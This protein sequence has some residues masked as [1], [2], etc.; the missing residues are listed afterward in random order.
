MIDLNTERM[1]GR[2]DVTIDGMKVNRLFGLNDLCIKYVD[3]N[4]KLLE[5]GCNDLVSTR[6]FCHYAGFVTGVDRRMSPQVSVTK[7]NFPTFEFVND[8]FDSYISKCDTKFDLIYIDGDHLYD[9]V[10]RD[11]RSSLKIIKPGGLI[12]GH[13]YYTTTNSGVPKAVSDMLGEYGEPEI[14]SD[15]SWVI[16]L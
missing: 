13:D 5:L 16:K 14:F 3:K 10:V 11:I 4:T 1:K 12:T 15:S 9:S 8:S 7:E 6:L 2:G